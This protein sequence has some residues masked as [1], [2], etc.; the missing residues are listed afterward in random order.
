MF[1]T[2][3]EIKHSHSTRTRTQWTMVQFEIAYS[4]TITIES[5]KEL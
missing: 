4:T 5:D 3:L 2:I 1:W